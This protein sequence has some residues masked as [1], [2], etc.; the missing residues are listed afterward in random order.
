MIDLEDNLDKAIVKKARSAVEHQQSIEA[1]RDAQHA[2]TEAQI[3]E[4]EAKSDLTGLKGRNMA[5]MQKLDEEKKKI[6]DLE[7]V[8]RQR[9]NE[10]SVLKS[11]ATKILETKDKDYLAGFVG[12]KSTTEVDEDIQAEEAKL[13][14]I[15]A[16]NP[17]VLRDFEKRAREIEKLREQMETAQNKGD[18]LNRE[19]SRIRE[20]FEPEVDELI[21]KVNDA[22][23]YNFEQIS[24]AGEVRVHKDDDFDQWALQILVKFR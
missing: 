4:T 3:R 1:I 9:R 8:K 6:V 10:A 24:C 12:E 5:I 21:S 16:A 11:E 15:H 18:H 14:L 7:Q 22:F 17:N 23:A 13:E 20:K 19:I 2:L